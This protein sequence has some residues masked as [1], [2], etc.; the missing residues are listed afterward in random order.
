MCGARQ[1]R[2]GLFDLQ[3]QQHTDDRAQGDDAGGDGQTDI[4]TAEAGGLF[5]H[6]GRWTRAAC[7]GSWRCGCCGTRSAG[8]S[9]RTRNRRLSCARAGGRTR[10]C[11][12]GSTRARRHRDGKI[13]GRGHGWRR[14]SSRS[15]WATGGQCGQFD[16]GRRCGLW[17]QTDAY[18]FLLGLNLGRFSG[19]GR[20]WSRGHTAGHVGRIVS[21]TID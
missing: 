18:G 13:G 12:C 20:H 19:F 2:G 11:R 3:E 10:R 6:C 7:C 14:R 15:D 9:G 5:C 21:H 1:F 17:R 16:R 4:Q 8:R